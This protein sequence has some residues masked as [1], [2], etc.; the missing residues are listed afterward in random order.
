ML[1]R[2]AF[3]SLQHGFLMTVENV[4]IHNFVTANG[5][6]GKNHVHNIQDFIQQIKDIKLQEDQCMMSFDVKA[7]FTSVPIQ[8]AIN[9][10][11]KLLEEDTELHKR[12]SLSVKNIIT[13]LLEFCLTSTYF[14]FQGRYFEQQEAAAMGSPISPIVA[15][16]SM[17]AFETKA[18]NTAPQPPLFLMICGW[19]LYHTPVIPKNKFPGTS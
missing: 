4:F 6:W 15:N 11:K 18:I 10:T 1:R 12:T 16:L 5:V 9:T 2:Q 3:A 7:L 17:E 13:S 8:P 19:H 14:I